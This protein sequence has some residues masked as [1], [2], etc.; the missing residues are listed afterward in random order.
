M[1][2]VINYGLENYSTLKMEVLRFFETSLMTHRN[3][4]E[5]LN[6]QVISDLKFSSQRKFIIWLIVIYSYFCRVLHFLPS[7]ANNKVNKFVHNKYSCHSTHL[8]WFG[9]LGY[10]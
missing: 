3:I 1:T 9:F 2:D 5:D 6:L 7:N 10:P 4:P 8:T